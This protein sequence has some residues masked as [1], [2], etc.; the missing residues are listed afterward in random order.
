[1]NLLPETVWLTLKPSAIE[2]IGVFAL[3]DIPKGT[4]V[5]WEYDTVE[6][7]TLSEVEFKALPIE[8]QTEI[9]HRTIFEEG[10]PLT[11]L[12]PNCVTNYRSYMNHSNEPN[13][14]GIHTL[15]DIKAGEEITEDYTS[16]GVW[17]SLTKDFM[18]NVV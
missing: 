11:F 10:Q 2:G 6:T 8:I 17:H 16:M 4:K 1:M 18:K 3:R 5:V 9:Q 14:D 7:V 13:T 12:D 15:R